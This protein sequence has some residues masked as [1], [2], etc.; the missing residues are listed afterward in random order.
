M[1]TKGL[2]KIVLA[3]IKMCQSGLSY[4]NNIQSIVFSVAEK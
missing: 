2:S 4:K 1:K 3:K